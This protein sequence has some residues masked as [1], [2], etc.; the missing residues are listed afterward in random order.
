MKNAKLF[1]LAALVL[2][3]SGCGKDKAEKPER[4]A[5]PE[6]NNSAVGSI[7]SNLLATETFGAGLAKFA[8]SSQASACARMET[9][10]ADETDFQAFSVFSKFIAKPTSRVQR[11]PPQDRLL[12]E[13]ASLQAL[14]AADAQINLQD[15]PFIRYLLASEK[16]LGKIPTR[17]GFIDYLNNAYANDEIGAVKYY[18]ALAA[19]KLNDGAADLLRFMG[20]NGSLQDKFPGVFGEPSAMKSSLYLNLIANAAL[21]KN[22]NVR[23]EQLRMQDVHDILTT[24]V[25]MID[26]DGDWKSF[27]NDMYDSMLAVLSAQ[28]RTELD[29]AEEQKERLCA[30]VLWQRAW[31]QLLSI[32]GYTSPKLVRYGGGEYGIQKFAADSDKADYASKIGIMP[33]AFNAPRGV[34]TPDLLANYSGE[35][36]IFLKDSFRIGTP[37]FS[38]NANLAQVL[39]MANAMALFFEASSPASPWYLEGVPYL[40]GDVEARGSGA[41]LPAEAHLL[42]LGLMKVNLTNLSTVF[43]KKI[44]LDGLPVDTSKPEDSREGRAT[45]IAL[46]DQPAAGVRN[47]SMHIDRVV[48]LTDAAIRLETYLKDLL[49]LPVRGEQEF[50]LKATVV[51]NEVIKVQQVPAKNISNE[52]GASQQ[53][54]ELVRQASLQNLKLLQVASQVNEFKL[55]KNKQKVYASSEPAARKFIDLVNEIRKGRGSKAIDYDK[56]DPEVVVKEQLWKTDLQHSRLSSLLVKNAAYKSETALALL[57]RHLLDGLPAEAQREF[58]A[59]IKP[60]KVLLNVLEQLKFSLLA[61][62]LKMADYKEEGC[63]QSLDMN[64]NEGREAPGRACSAEN[65][66]DILRAL[67]ALW[68]SYGRESVLI[69]RRYSALK[70]QWGM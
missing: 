23:I 36:V 45:G 43:L 25:R 19:A 39:H 37:E 33:G 57:G 60:G 50:W 17:E 52:S 66:Q 38:A 67:A 31:N 42:A 58:D 70:R 56:F 35:P 59:G 69:S 7:D 14:A 10:R 13:R 30:F 51:N 65:K 8:A 29:S 3:V 12:S 46:F 40:F 32:N 15:S 61:T 44:N 1:F 6:V 28:K 16:V 63:V 20:I 49:A 21:D 22:K 2:L 18:A 54:R 4:V 5:F 48:M 64:L 11:V 68:D 27:E 47:S 34:L 41:V 55:M 26:G 53:E 62:I 9:L 24:R